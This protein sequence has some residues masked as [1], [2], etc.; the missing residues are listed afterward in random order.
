ML[1]RCCFTGS[2]FYIISRSANQTQSSFCAVPYNPK[3]QLQVKCRLFLRPRTFD[4][5][6]D[7]SILEYFPEMDSYENLNQ[8]SLLHRYNSHQVNEFL[9]RCLHFLFGQSVLFRAA[10]LGKFGE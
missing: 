10:Q 9:C 8:L 3:H 7:Q 2:C 1:R 5:I 6:S 4:R